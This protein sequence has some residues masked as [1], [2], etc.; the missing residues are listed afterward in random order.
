MTFFR[1]IVGDGYKRARVVIRS[2]TWRPAPIKGW[3]Q[4]KWK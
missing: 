1:D 4:K 2:S 3:R